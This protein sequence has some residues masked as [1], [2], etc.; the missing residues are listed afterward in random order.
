MFYIGIFIFLI[1]FGSC[2][3]KFPLIAEQNSY[4]L[5]LIIYQWGKMRKIQ[6]NMQ[7]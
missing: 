3:I 6:A 7:I 5:W 4:G 1:V 2:Q